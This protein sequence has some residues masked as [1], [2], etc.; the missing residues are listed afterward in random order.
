MKRLLLVFVV[1]L[2]LGAGGAALLLPPPAE[3]PRAGTPAGAAPADTRAQAAIRAA[4]ERLRARLRIEGPMT[5]RAVQVHRQALADSLAV[6]GQINAS[7]RADEPFM[8]YVA[9][10][11]FEGDRVARGEFFLGA[12]SSEAARVYIEMVD[13]CFDGGGPANARAAVRPIPPIPAELP[14]AV[15]SGPS[16]SSSQPPT[17]AAPPPASATPPVMAAPSAPASGSV[18]TSSRTPVNIRANPSGGGQVVRTVPR[19]SNLQ[20]FGEAPGGWLQVGE[21]EAW[22]WV[23]SSMLEVR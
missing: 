10:L 20:V 8:P 3:A 13:K 19:G 17:T 15:P 14:R 2:L 12:S 7:G 9:I 16:V 11:G 18:M 1:A 5:L 6:C 23:H 21:G 22:G 4:E